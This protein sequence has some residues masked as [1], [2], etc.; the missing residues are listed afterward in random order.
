[1]KKKKILLITEGLGS[2]VQK[3]QSVNLL[4]LLKNGSQ[5]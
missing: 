4:R 3:D 1:M 5:P 2:G